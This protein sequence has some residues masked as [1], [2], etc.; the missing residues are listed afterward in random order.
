[1]GDQSQVAELLR[2]SGVP[3]EPDVATPDTAVF[4]FPLSYGAGRTR[5][6]KRVPL[7]EQAAIVAMLQ[8]CWADNAV[9][10]T[11]TFQPDEAKHVGNVLSLFAPL[12][13][14]M[15]LMPDREGVYAQMPVEPSSR[16]DFR[17][18]TEAL[19]PVRWG[20]LRGHDGA[21]SEE[22]YCTTDAC[23]VAPAPA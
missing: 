13:K 10:N 2:E 18:R 11:L 16:E 12:V 20:A 15:S 7:Y 19:R 5:S 14:S 3:W 6:V 9:S 4:S 22:L 17:A 21:E 8:R 23:E 1:M